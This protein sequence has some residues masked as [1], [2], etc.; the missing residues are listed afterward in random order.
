ML[1]QIHWNPDPVIF[2]VLGFGLRWY[3]LFWMIGLA[4]ALVVAGRVFKARG[5][6]ENDFN[7]LFVYCVVGIFV[8]ARLGHCLFY[9]R[10]VREDILVFLAHVFHSCIQ[11]HIIDRP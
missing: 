1:A 6:S 10:Q 2:Q 4:A 11:L 5:L 9:D 3:S 7:R 8:G